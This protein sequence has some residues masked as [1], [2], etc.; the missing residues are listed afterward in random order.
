MATVAPSVMMV[1]R[2]MNTGAGAVMDDILERVPPQNLEAE[3]SVLGA[4]LLDERCLN[5]ALEVMQ[6]DD[7]YRE[8]HRDIFLAMLELTAGKAA[9]DRSRS[10]M[11]CVREA[12][13]MRSEARPISSSSP[14]ASRPQRTSGI[15]PGS[16]R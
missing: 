12:S 7:F 6:P 9:V 8:T 13:S 11:L 4:I 2:W 14:S 10:A 3:Q 16:S 15:T 5:R 1:P